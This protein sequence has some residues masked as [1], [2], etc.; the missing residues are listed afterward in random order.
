[1]MPDLETRLSPIAA[2][3]AAASSLY[4]RLESDYALAPAGP[5]G[6]AAI[7][8]WRKL[9][10]QEDEKRFLERL[11]HAGWDLD[12]LTRALSGP[13]TLRADALPPWAETLAQVLAKASPDATPPD[14]T[15]G[16][17]DREFPFQELLRFFV[18]IASERL[19]QR[20]GER[21]GL[22]SQ[23]ALIA[24]ER[25]LMGQLVETAGQTLLKEFVVFRHFRTM[26]LF[27]PGLNRGSKTH[28]DA[29]IQQHLSTGLLKLFESYPVL[30][31]LLATSVDDW[32]E[33]VSEFLFHL[34]ADWQDLSAR[35]APEGL[36]QVSGIELGLSDRH[37]AG[38]SVIKVRFDA[39]LTL[40][41]KPRDLGLEAA[42]NSLLDWLN[43]QSETDGL[44]AL[45]ALA[46][47]DRGTHG[48]M[49][50]A[51][52]RP[53]RD[54]EE[55]K[56]YYR[57]AGMLIALVYLL[58]GT[59]LHRENLIACGDQPIL[60]DL[61]ML[62]ASSVR[63]PLSQDG[64]TALGE[65][66]QASV[67]I[68]GL[69]PFFPLQHQG[70]ELSA[71][72]GRIFAEKI[73]RHAWCEINTD[74]MSYAPVVSSPEAL[75]ANLPSLDG[76][77]RLPHL[78]EAELVE[79]F[80]AM[81]RWLMTH[82]SELPLEG[83][84]RRLSRHMLRNTNDYALVLAKAK[85]P[86]FLKDGAAR[87]LQI[88]RLASRLLFE[89]EGNRDA[90]QQLLRMEHLAL[91]RM[92][93]PR[94]VARTDAD[95]LWVDEALA[96]PGYFD[97]SGWEIV[98]KRLR[99]LSEKDLALQVTLIRGALKTSEV[100]TREDFRSAW[101]LETPA[102]SG[103]LAPKDF[104]EEAVRIGEDLASQAVTAGRYATWYQAV[105][106]FASER[107][108]YRQAEADLHSGTAGIGLFLAALG[109][110]TGET[111]FADLGRAALA[112][113][114][115]LA[116]RWNGP[117]SLGAV[118]GIGSLLYAFT[119]AGAL[120]GC[121]ELLEG[122]AMAS[123]GITTE[124]IA[125]DTVFDVMAGSAGSI[126]A[127]L[128]YQRVTGDET[129]LERA[130]ACG[131]HLLA[132]RIDMGRGMRTWKS[133]SERP[134]CGFSH[135]ASG[136]AYALVKLHAATGEPAFREA[137]LEAIAYERACFD[138]AEGN[139]PDL[140]V[141][142]AEDPAFMC[143]WCHGAPGI[144]LGRLGG[145]VGLD[146]AQVRGEIETGLA[147]T[148]TYPLNGADHLCCGNFGRI[149]IL[150]EASQWLDR[151][152]LLATA[153]EQASWAIQRA[154]AVGSYFY[155]PMLPPGTPYHGLFSGLAGIGYG[156]L[157][158]ADPKALPSLLRIE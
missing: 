54:A 36:R 32:V 28:Y 66:L 21:L 151:P 18:L 86:A 129:A 80:T 67:L 92:D 130:L 78:E 29:F 77:V 81:Y 85:E 22:L 50:A 116:H 132:H 105:Y 39:S 134:L 14:A 47:L 94:F 70:Q 72:T 155:S 13:P 56:R 109:A 4:E 38:R 147:K 128:A 136:I 157:R 51:E 5:E 118:T 26:S 149:D 59:D 12:T 126:L 115:E 140:R 2:I 42:F 108:V 16:V 96:V 8:Q 152:D 55:V 87:S 3:A 41:Y 9:A 20:A 138:P 31:R 111:R 90:I 122:A 117:V 57:R 97:K 30:G 142:P 73:T 45:R 35:F 58:N 148:L 114:L 158:I 63:G 112:S 60:V 43:Q 123:R 71:L 44:E 135:G 153:R 27:F 15:E 139:W 110:R 7:A 91:E 88:D 69:L 82:A 62:L 37:Q 102:A 113:P 121:E 40:V 124:A 11:S 6:E 137:A 1:M 99:S 145:L 83:F 79:G 141:E 95:A 154:R 19:K 143:S 133:I 131:R 150:A 146:D 17:F 61:E 107:V 52:S 46:V 120:L 65:V 156:L 24:F 49:E 125:Q 10:A 103:S 74:E 33:A 89:R 119:R 106:D 76:E 34:E 25:Q 84:K 98:S 23:D 127:L 100:E 104:M 64:S 48:W 75:P 68:S 101:E 93:V 144:T 53:C